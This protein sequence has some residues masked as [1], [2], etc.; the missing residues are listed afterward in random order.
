MAYVPLDGFLFRA[1]LLPMTAVAKGPRALL[2]HP[3]GREAIGIASPDLAAAIER[4]RAAARITG[5]DDDPDAL[6]ELLLSMVDEG[7]LI[8]DVTAP[9][10]G[11]PPDAWLTERLAA[12]PAAAGAARALAAAAADAHAGRFAAARAALAA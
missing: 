2:A 4:G 11:P 5:E 1:P 6:D 8:S 10:V 9:L 12:I 3:L 7:L